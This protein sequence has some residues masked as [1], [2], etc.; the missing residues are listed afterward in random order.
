LLFGIDI[1]LFL[2][3]FYQESQYGAHHGSNTSLASQ[4]RTGYWGAV[5]ANIDWCEENYVHSNYV[6]EVFNTFSNL[7]YIFVGVICGIRHFLFWRHNKATE[8]G[9]F[10]WY[11]DSQRTG[12]AYLVLAVTGA[13]SMLFHAMLTKE[14]QLADELPL[15]WLIFDYF[16][17]HAVAE[18]RSQQV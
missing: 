8:V 4:S 11:P 5:T 3:V 13:G 16:L 6:A 17:Q 7:P 15:S 18:A 2:L 9:H 12:Y 10:N 1:S 14:S